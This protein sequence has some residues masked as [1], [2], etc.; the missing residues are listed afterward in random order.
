MAE[1]PGSNDPLAQLLFDLQNDPAAR[2]HARRNL[3]GFLARYHLPEPARSELASGDAERWVIV[4]RQGPLR[5]IFAGER[6]TYMGQAPVQTVEAYT[7]EVYRD[8]GP[9]GN[10]AAY[11]GSA[12]V[13]NDAAYMGSAPV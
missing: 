11:M 9:A 4:F 12:P 13:G 8:T 3:H 5:A 7:A 6:V 1:E 2:L 10:D